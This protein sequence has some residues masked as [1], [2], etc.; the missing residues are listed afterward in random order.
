MVFVGSG[1]SVSIIA[2]WFS[3]EILSISIE[4]KLVYA[5]ILFIHTSSEYELRITVGIISW[6]N[7][8]VTR[9]EGPHSMYRNKLANSEYSLK[10]N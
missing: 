5:S 3:I 6:R 8:V 9:S 1:S 10:I 4:I 2:Y 7:K